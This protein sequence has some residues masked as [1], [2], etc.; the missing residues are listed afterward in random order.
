MPD[1]NR[2]SSAHQLN[3]DHKSLHDL[4]GS[5]NSKYTESVSPPVNQ[6]F[7]STSVGHS[8]SRH[9]SYVETCGKYCRRGSTCCYRTDFSSVALHS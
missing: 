5:V 2:I 4:S 1:K 9:F 8:R 7:P 3:I 6:V